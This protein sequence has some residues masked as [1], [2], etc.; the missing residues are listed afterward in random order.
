MPG[1]K[2]LPRFHAKGLQYLFA[3]TK[4]FIDCRRGS[5]RLFGNSAH[6]N[7][8]SPPRFHSLR[9]AFRMRCSRARVRMTGH[10]CL[11]WQTIAEG[12]INLDDVK[13][14]TYNY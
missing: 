8:C 14:T 11:L 1:K 6:G 7:A 4:T 3:V 12:N 13:L 9:A 10:S 5:A 2:F